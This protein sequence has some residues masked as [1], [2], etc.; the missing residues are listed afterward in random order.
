MN[1][2]RITAKSVHFKLHEGD[3]NE[4]TMNTLKKVAQEK[5]FKHV[6]MTCNG[7][8]LLSSNKQIQMRN[9]ERT[10]QKWLG[11]EHLPMRIQDF[12]PLPN[13]F[14][15]NYFAE[16]YNAEKVLYKIGKKFEDAVI[17][18]MVKEKEHEESML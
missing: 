12:D 14:L 4:K 13:A 15:Q 17:S 16:G 8:I 5:G 6:M 2:K 10:L 7:D 9:G 1:P 3:T 18:K 11:T